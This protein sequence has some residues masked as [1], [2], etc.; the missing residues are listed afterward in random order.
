[1]LFA[2]ILVLCIGVTQGCDV[3]DT[4]KLNFTSSFGDAYTIAS[5]EEPGAIVPRL[6]ADGLHV[7]VQYSGGCREHEFVVRHAVHHDT[8]EIWLFHDNNGDACEAYLTDTRL[9]SVPSTVYNTEHVVLL[10]P[11]GT[12][13][14]LR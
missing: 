11:E 5:H 10:A 8:T 9:L 4:L 1:M 13:F 6:G 3:T 2:L 7:S 12:E 14:S